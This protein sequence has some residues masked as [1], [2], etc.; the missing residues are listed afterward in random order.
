[1][2]NNPQLVGNIIM[3]AGAI[4][5]LVAVIGV[6]GLALP[7]IIAG[8]SAVG[9]VLAVLTGPIGLVIGAVALLA[10]AWATNFMGIQEKTSAVW[11]WI[12]TTFQAGMDWIM[13]KIQPFLDEISKFWSANGDEIITNLSAFWEGVKIVFTELFDW[14]KLYVGVAWEVISGIFSV[15][16]TLIKAN[17]EIFFTVITGVMTA[18]MQVINGDWSGAWNTVK[19]TFESVGATI[20]SAGGAVFEK[21]Y[22]IVTGIVARI[23]AYISEKLTAVKNMLREIVTLGAANTSPKV[24]GAKANGGMVQSGKTYLV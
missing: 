22:S 10:T 23:E 4:S 6:V 12:T 14:I 8:F 16:F 13:G 11:D 15:A 9:T 3:I 20:V 24:D 5:G 17:F 2:E 7:S 1:M 21:L 18:G 19:T